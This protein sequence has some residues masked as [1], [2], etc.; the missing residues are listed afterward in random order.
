MK[1][2]KPTK[3]PVQKHQLKKYPPSKPSYVSVVRKEFKPYEK[4][5]YPPNMY[6]RYRSLHTV[7]ASNTKKSERKHYRN[8]LTTA[9]NNKKSQGYQRYEQRYELS[10]QEDLLQPYASF[11][12]GEEI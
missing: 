9:K 6:N 7:P 1:T 10:Q 11:K 12:T 5:R 2:K 8:D 3:V 4:K